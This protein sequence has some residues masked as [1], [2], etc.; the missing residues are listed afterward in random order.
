METNP[1]GQQVQYFGPCYEG[2]PLVGYHYRLLR[3]DP[4]DMAFTI[5]RAYKPGNPLDYVDIRFMGTSFIQLPIYWQDWPFRLAEQDACSDVQSKLGPEF[6]SSTSKLIYTGSRRR[7]WQILAYDCI[8]FKHGSPEPDWIET[9]IQDESGLDLDVSLADLSPLE[10]AAFLR[11]WSFDYRISGL[12]LSVYTASKAEYRL[13][14]DDVYYL[15]LPLHARCEAFRVPSSDDKQLILEQIGFPQ[16]KHLNLL[17]SQTYQ[18]PI[19]ILCG[20]VGVEA[21]W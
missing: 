16:A 4:S 2:E 10:T 19:Y 6:M 11:A 13:V 5:V 15:Q 21:P 20:K 8:L 18:M 7:M 9:Q 17:Q 3:F 1:A 12:T 14:C